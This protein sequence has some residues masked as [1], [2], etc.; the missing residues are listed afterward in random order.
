MTSSP[1][2]KDPIISI[3][4]TDP[5]VTKPQYERPDYSHTKHSCGEKDLGTYA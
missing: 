2:Q 1:L 4:V 3:K 5:H